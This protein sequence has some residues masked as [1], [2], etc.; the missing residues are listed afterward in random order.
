MHI[1]GKVPPLIQESDQSVLAFVQKVPGAIGY[2]SAGMAPQN[3]KVLAR[4]P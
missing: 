2:I 1:K 4:V 3:V